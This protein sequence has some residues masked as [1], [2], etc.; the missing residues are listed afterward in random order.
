MDYILEFTYYSQTTL[1]IYDLAD[2]NRAFLELE[3]NTIKTE[4]GEDMRKKR[5]M[6][7]A[8]TKKEVTTHQV[9]HISPKKK[10]ASSYLLRI[11]PLSVNWQD[12]MV[13][14]MSKIYQ[15]KKCGR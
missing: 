7:C 9:K 11:T 13:Q 6:C 5:K 14:R 1:P 10:T 3:I 12:L 8:I 15:G 2:F 4:I